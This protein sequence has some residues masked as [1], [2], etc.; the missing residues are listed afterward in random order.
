MRA[1]RLA[2]S[3]SS[4]QIHRKMTK[5]PA[6]LPQHLQPSVDALVAFAHSGRGTVPRPEFDGVSSWCEANEDESGIQTGD[7]GD[8]F[9]VAWLKGELPGC[10]GEDI[11]MEGEADVASL[12]DKSRLSYLKERLEELFDQT[13]EDAQLFPMGCTIRI[14]A[15]TGKTASLGYFL[16]G[17]GYMGDLT[18][19]WQGVYRSERG[20]RAAIRQQEGLTSMADVRKTSDP[21]LLRLWRGHA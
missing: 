17:G 11:E 8:G 13:T 16:S 20:F 10:S 3:T 15:S 5:P 7:H 19:E 4:V 12:S 1:R 14:R 21:T 6:K 18:V 2:G 9:I